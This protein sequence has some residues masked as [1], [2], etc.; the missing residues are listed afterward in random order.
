MRVIVNSTPLIALALVEKLNLLH[1]LFDEV[2][3]PQ[4]VYDEVVTYGLG[5]AGTNTVAQATW[6]TVMTTTAQTTLEPLLLGL[7]PGEM[8]VLLLA[9]ELAPDWVIID[10]RLGRRVAKA[11]RMPTKGTLGILLAAVITGLID[12]QEALAATTEMIA[13]GIR[14]SPR[15]QN[16][17]K[18][19]LEK[20][21][22]EPVI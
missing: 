3:V 12:K 9:Q 20:L 13:G 18:D 11:L 1:Q 21:E 2:I 10:E 14:I 19:E 15:W 17:L 16:W 5:R 8:E 22:E 4:A 6:I 7:D